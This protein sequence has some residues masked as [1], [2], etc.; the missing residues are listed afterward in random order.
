M[1]GKDTRFFNIYTIICVN[2]VTYKVFC[3]FVNSNHTHVI[4]VL[5]SDN[6][7]HIDYEIQQEK[8]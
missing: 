3:F 5:Q 8:K 6:R 1:D 7:I 4:A 2:V